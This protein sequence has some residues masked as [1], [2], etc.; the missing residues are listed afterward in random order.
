MIKTSFHIALQILKVSWQAMLTST[1]SFISG[2]SNLKKLY[3]STFGTVII[4]V[5]IPAFVGMK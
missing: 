3:H 4:I 2:K 5:M 1:L